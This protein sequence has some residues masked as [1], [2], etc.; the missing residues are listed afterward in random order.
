MGIGLVYG[1]WLGL[2]LFTVLATTGLIYRIHV[3]ET[4]LSEELGDRYRSY[5]VARKRL[6]PYVW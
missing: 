2:V 6:I 5:A 3:E 1:N 4:A